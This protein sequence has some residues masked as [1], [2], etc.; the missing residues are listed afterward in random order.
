MKNDLSIRTTFKYNLGHSHLDEWESIGTV[1]VIA[2]ERK[3]KVDDSGDYGSFF[4]LVSV[5]SKDTPERIKTALMEQETH[6][7]RCKYDCCGHVAAYSPNARKVGNSSLW[8][9]KV[10]FSRNC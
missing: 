10:N 1:S 9:V 6:S 7:C 5:V 2:P 8:V 3:R 4:R